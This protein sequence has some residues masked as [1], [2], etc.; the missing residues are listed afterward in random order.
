MSDLF[1][2]RVPLGSNILLSPDNV[3]AI[4]LLNLAGAAIE[5]TAQVRVELRSPVGG[6]EAEPILG[7]TLYQTFAPGGIGEF[8]HIEQLVT[9]Q[10]PA[11][12]QVIEQAFIV[13]QAQSAVVIDATRSW[14][15]LRTQE[16]KV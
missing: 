4:H 6:G 1:S 8:R 7:A 5:P 2:Y 11:P 12:R 16:V 9:L 13:V 15:E 14:F 3:L 10:I